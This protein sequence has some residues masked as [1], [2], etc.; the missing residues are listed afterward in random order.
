[1]NTILTG[2]LTLI[3]LISSVVFILS[4]VAARKLWRDI[5]RFITPPAENEP[6]G[7]ALLLAQI[8]HQSGQ[9]IAQEVKTTMM[10]KE[11]G[12]KRGEQALGADVLTDVVDSQSPILGAILDGFP[13]LKKRL[14]KNPGLV[15][16]ALNLVGGIGKAGNGGSG[17][18]GGGGASSH[19]SAFH[20]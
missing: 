16:A 13:T 2:V 12:M 1:M 9:A 10:G 15:G 4:V 6:S 20:I 17:P 5:V 7:L 18:A 8:A 14:M 11:S 19:Q 3:C